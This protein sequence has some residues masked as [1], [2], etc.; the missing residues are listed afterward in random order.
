VSFAALGPGARA[1]TSVHD[2]YCHLGD[3][4]PLGWLYEADAAI[5]LLGVGY[6]ACTAF[7]LA[8]HR[9]PGARL[10]RYHCFTN[11][12]GMRVSRVFTDID[13]DDSDFELLG[14]ALDSAAG[15]DA[16]PVVRRGQVGSAACRLV[17]LRVAVDFACAWMADHR[18]GA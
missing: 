12:G 6:S 5:A 1:C 4:S 2:L 9:L 13:F 3:R 7:H 18:R 15:S 8:E 14:A 11:E 17:R 10:R 16:A